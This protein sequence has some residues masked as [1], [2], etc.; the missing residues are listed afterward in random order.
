MSKKIVLAS[1]NHG[2]QKELQARLQ[3]LQWNMILQS[4][5]SVPEAD[6]T[7]STFI[8]NATIKAKN[9]AVHTGLAALADDSGLVVPA[10]AGRPGIHSSRYAGKNSSYPEK[11]AKLF[12]EIDVLAQTPKT[13]DAYFYCVLVFMRQADDPAPI[14]A[15]GSWHGKLV[16]ASGSSGFGYDPIFYVPTEGC[17]AA[18]LDINTKAQISHRGQAL[19]ALLEKIS[20]QDI[21]TRI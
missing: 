8:E 14:I 21:N 4:D 6:E 10:L 9:A 17:T 15:E 7:G 16:A 20:A 11:F 12:G 3:P 1:G 5:L 19:D 18:E 13:I 2:K